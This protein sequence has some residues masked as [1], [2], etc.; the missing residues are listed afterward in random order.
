M[1][2]VSFKIFHYLLSDVSQYRFLIFQYQF[3]IIQ[4]NFSLSNF[5]D[6]LLNVCVS[7]CNISLRLASGF[8]RVWWVAR[9]RLKLTYNNVHVWPDKDLSFQSTFHTTLAKYIAKLPISP[10]LPVQQNKSGWLYNGV[11]VCWLF[12]VRRDSPYSP[13]PPSPAELSQDQTRPDQIRPDQTIP[14]Q[15]KMVQR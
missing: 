15:T 8:W 4:W 12:V 9:S 2:N 10:D 3:P 13:W 6:Q 5:T 1:S 7:L 14:Y 11:V